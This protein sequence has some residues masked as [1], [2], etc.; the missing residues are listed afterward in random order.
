MA[1]RRKSGAVKGKAMEKKWDAMFCYGNVLIAMSREGMVSYR[2]ASRGK[3]QAM[4]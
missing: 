2:D 1:T 3:G 4:N